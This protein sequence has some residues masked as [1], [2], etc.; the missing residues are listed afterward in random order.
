MVF[1]HSWW[2][3][4][5]LLSQLY[6]ILLEFRDQQVY[7]L[8]R[9]LWV[10]ESLVLRKADNR[11]PIRHLCCNLMLKVGIQ[12]LYLHFKRFNFYSANIAIVDEAASPRPLLV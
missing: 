1:K 3:K 6:L 8:A 11:V 12:T 9:V 2:V 10:L 4:Y 5:A 7:Q